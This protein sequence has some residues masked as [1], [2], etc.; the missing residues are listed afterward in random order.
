M[1]SFLRG[2]FI[3][4]AHLPLYHSFSLSKGTIRTY[5]ADGNFGLSFDPDCHYWN[6]GVSLKVETAQT[7]EPA[8]M[9]LLGSGLIGPAGL[10]PE[11]AFNKS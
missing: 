4:Y 3:F 8:T 1:T 9:L 6:D 7:P 2:L 10:K 11:K 5:S